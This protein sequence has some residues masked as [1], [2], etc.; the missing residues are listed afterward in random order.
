MNL[1]ETVTSYNKTG[2]RSTSSRRKLST[3]W[4]DDI[5]VFGNDEGRLRRLQ[6]DLEETARSMELELH[7]AKT[8]IY[9]GDELVGQALQTA[10]SAV[11]TALTEPLF[12]EDSPDTSP[13]RELLGSLLEEPEAADRSS[14]HFVCVRLRRHKLKEEGARLPEKAERMPH[15][16]DHLS[17]LAHDLGLWKSHQNWYA[18]YV[19]S[20]WARFSWSVAQLATMFPSNAK[21]SEKVV[22]T[23]AEL[24]D[25][26]PD[27]PVL[28]VGIQRLARW[29]SDTA[30]DLLRTLAARADHPL[31]RR[32]LAL[33]SVDL[34]EP[35][36]RIRELLG[37]YPE[38]QLT[39]QLIEERGFKKLPTAE[40]FR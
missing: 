13:L 2:E 10:H 23:L 32:L 33:G 26:M 38:N 12:F 39:L 24:V 17:R 28:A 40:D 35:R 3:R 4:M 16:A 34:R 37:A 8:G 7:A 20:D 11:D 22:S 21:V 29:D 25:D 19:K 18:D 31:E 14:V 36:H 27:L 5:W 30:K 15:V 9:E 6:V 1:D